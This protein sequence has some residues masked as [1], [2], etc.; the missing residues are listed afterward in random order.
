MK[1]SPCNFGRVEEFLDYQ[2]VLSES[3][4]ENGDQKLN[5]GVLFVKN[6]E[7][8][9]HA[10]NHAWNMFGED[11][12]FCAQDAFQNMFD[13]HWFRGYFSVERQKRFNSF[14]YCEYGMSDHTR[15]HFT[16]GDFALHLPGCTT[17][18]RVA[19]FNNVKVIK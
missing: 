7:A 16:E 18:R 6:S 5:D 10:L 15:G 3:I 8:S 4:R 9:I 13:G 2:I 19:I 17:Q 12:I 1:I 11:K 14:L